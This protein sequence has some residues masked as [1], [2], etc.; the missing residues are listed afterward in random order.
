MR[1]AAHASFYAALITSLLVACHHRDDCYDCGGDP[2]PYYYESEP[3]DQACCADWLGSLAP[4]ETA[5]IRGS[6]TSFGPDYFDGFAFV[7][8]QPLDV[9]VELVSDDPH[10][11]FDICIYDP[12][13]GDYVA[14]FETSAQPEV[15][16]FSVLQTGRE[17]HVVV[18]PYSGS[19]S[20][21]L[22]VDGL[23]ISFAAPTSTGAGIVRHGDPTE[24]RV[25]EH[26]LADYHPEVAA[27]DAPARPVE[28]P[29]E[30]LAIDEHGDVTRFPVRI[31]RA[32]AG[33]D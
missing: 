24:P 16:L 27:V 20:Y 14:C 1:P 28:L 2:D 9:R 26:A 29:A 19:G 33:R 22:Y 15:G 6:I 23:P 18:T 12:L 32:T 3:N 5:A 13:I 11:D 8:A 10:D 31:L 7:A 30:I 4:Y 21:S 25:R 17:F